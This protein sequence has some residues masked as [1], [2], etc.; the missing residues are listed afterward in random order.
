MP[1]AMIDAEPSAAS[2]LSEIRR[3]DAAVLATVRG[4]QAHI[5]AIGTVRSLGMDQAG[6]VI[7]WVKT[8]KNA[9]LDGETELPAWKGKAA[10]EITGNKAAALSELARHTFP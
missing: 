6:V 1:L 8:S 9:F 4:E 5:M 10:F 7:D 2:V 3:G